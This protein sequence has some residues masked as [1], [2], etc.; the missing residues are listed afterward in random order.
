L[1]V[2]IRIGKNIRIQDEHPGSFHFS[3][4]LKTVV[5]NSNT[6]VDSDP[7]RIRNL[8]DPGTGMEK[9]GSGT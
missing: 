8:L 6:F 2:G 1:T 3:E 5:K 4:S 7:D 9:F